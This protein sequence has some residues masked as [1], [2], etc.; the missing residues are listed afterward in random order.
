MKEE[1]VERRKDALDKYIQGTF[2]FLLFS[3]YR[4]SPLFAAFA[5]LPFFYIRGVP[6]SDAHLGNSKRKKTMV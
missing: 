2:L 5:P 6:E 4:F 3:S 1:F